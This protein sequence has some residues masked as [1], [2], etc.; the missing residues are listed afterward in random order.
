MDGTL[1]MPQLLVVSWVLPKYLL[2]QSSQVLEREQDV[3]GLTKSNV[4][5]MRTVSP[6]VP[7]VL[8][9][10]QID[11]AD[12]FHPVITMELQVLYVQVRVIILNRSEYHMNCCKCNGL[13]AINYE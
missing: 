11:I 3:Y 13:T 7:E 4:R 12:S 6:S 5:E 2:L 1:K 8:G 10:S 9:G